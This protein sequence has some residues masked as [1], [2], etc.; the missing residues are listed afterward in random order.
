MINKRIAHSFAYI[1]MLKNDVR[2]AA[3]Q[4]NISVQSHKSS[5]L[6]MVKKFLPGLYPVTGRSD[7]DGLLSKGDGLRLQLCL[8]HSFCDCER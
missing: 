8:Q 7:L 3:R 5:V 6:K 4:T 2:L 1:L